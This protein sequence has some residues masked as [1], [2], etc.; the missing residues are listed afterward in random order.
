MGNHRF[1]WLESL[2]GNANTN[3]ALNFVGTTD[4]A[5]LAFRTNNAEHVRITTSGFVGIGTS[6]PIVKTHIENGSFL[7]ESPAV[8]PGSTPSASTLPT[9][10]GTRFLWNHNKAAFRMGTVSGNDWDDNN[11]GLLSF[12]AGYNTKASGTFSFVVG[13]TAEATGVGSTALG[14]FVSTIHDGSFQIG[15]SP[16]N[17]TVPNSILQSTREDQFSAR[18]WGGYR[19]LTRYDYQTTDINGVFIVPVDPAAFPYGTRTGFGTSAPVAKIHVVGDA[20]ITDLGGNGDRMVVTNNAGKLSTAPLPN[21]TAGTGININ[22]G[23]ISVETFSGGDLTGNM[24]NPQVTRIQGKLVAMPG[25]IANGSLLRWNQGLNRWEPFSG[26]S[27]TVN[28][29]GSNG[30]PC[31]MV[32]ENGL[33]ISTTCP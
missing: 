2:R 13:N 6:T 8:N 3:P 31:Q 26:F 9:G 17:S 22:S 33:L 5:D 14:K 21:Y 10:A 12:A 1:Y 7:I 32:Y 24:P 20:I 29:T 30:N 15:D 27:G 23:V 16:N 28:V 19:F 18:F 11:Q 4:N 25:I